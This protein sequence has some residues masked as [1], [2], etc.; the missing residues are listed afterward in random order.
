MKIVAKRWRID[1]EIT[2]L[3]VY[4]QIYLSN[5]KNIIM[6]DLPDQAMVLQRQSK[7]RNINN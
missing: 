1:Y 3:Y 4:Q 7:S 6:R 2:F 5:V